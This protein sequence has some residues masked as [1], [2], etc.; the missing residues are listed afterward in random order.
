MAL[1]NADGVLSGRG[2]MDCLQYYNNC[3]FSNEIPTFSP[4]I[5]FIYPKIPNFS[6]KIS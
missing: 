6:P 2:L 4:K 3:L 5:S 1:Q